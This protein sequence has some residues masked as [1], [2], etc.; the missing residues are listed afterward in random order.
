MFKLVIALLVFLPLQ[1]IYAAAENSNHPP[2]LYFEYNRGASLPTRADIDINYPGSFNLTFH[3]VR[4]TGKSFYPDDSII[5][6]A[7]LRPLLQGRFR[8]AKNAFTEPYYGLRITKFFKF[9]PNLGIGLEFV[10]LKVFIPDEGDT[11]R[12][13]GEDRG[14]PV[15]TRTSTKD[16]IDSFN[17]SHGVNHLNLF[18][19]YRLG[20]KKEAASS[21]S[22]FQPYFSAGYGPCIPHPQLRLKG[23]PQYKAYGHQ[24]TFRNNALTPGGGSRFQISK[25]FGLYFEGKLTQANLRELSFD[26]GETGTVRLKFL[27]FHLAWGIS[28]F[29]SE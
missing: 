18:V 14:I 16:Y 25:R 24:F 7:F 3:D 4:M 13:T 20:M 15:D 21:P 11:V 1:E 22:K 29:F 2:L 23:D 27:V 10:H 12:V 6:N 19:V 17:V 5:P 8:A 26:N 28:V 9:M